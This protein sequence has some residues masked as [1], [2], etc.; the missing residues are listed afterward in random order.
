MLPRVCMTPYFE[1]NP[2]HVNNEFL[3]KQWKCNIYRCN[4]LVR[5]TKSHSAKLFVFYTQDSRM[6]NAIMK[7]TYTVCTKEEKNFG[8]II[9]IQDYISNLYQYTMYLYSKSLELYGQSYRS[10]TRSK[11]CCCINNNCYLFWYHTLTIFCLL[12][13]FQCIIYG[14]GCLYCLQN[15]SNRCISSAMSMVG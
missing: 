8:F 13:P 2:L 5:S 15:Y 14:T 3:L 6:D 4:N 9:M 11:H 10:I 12:I 1:A 7:F